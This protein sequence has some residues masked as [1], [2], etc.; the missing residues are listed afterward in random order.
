V[1]R[2]EHLIIEPCDCDVGVPVDELLAV[3]QGDPCLAGYPATLV[4]SLQ[5][6][7]VVIEYPVPSSTL[8]L[9]M[10]PAPVSSRDGALPEVREWQVE[11]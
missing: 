4:P 10:L 2:H 7:D 5:A 8:S 1:G 3:I 6:I 9:R 11:Q